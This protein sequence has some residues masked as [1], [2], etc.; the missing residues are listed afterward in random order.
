MIKCPRLHLC[1]WSLQASTCGWHIGNC[2]LWLGY[3]LYIYIN[4]WWL[5]YVY[6]SPRYTWGKPGSHL[7][8]THLEM[9]TCRTIRNVDASG[10]IDL[11]IAQ[12]PGLVTPSIAILRLVSGGEAVHP[13][14][15]QWMRNI[16]SGNQT[17][18]W[19]IQELSLILPIKTPIFKAFSIAMFDYRR[20]FRS[21]PLQRMTS[22]LVLRLAMELQ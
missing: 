9:K 11:R 21:K 22:E 3:S 7:C 1:S 16:L 15:Y 14:S 4:C 12:K 17:W 8:P 18:P 13:R 19:H 20:T 2:I 10:R 6:V 5:I